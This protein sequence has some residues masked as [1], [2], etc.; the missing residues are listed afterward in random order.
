MDIKFTAKKR[1]PKIVSMLSMALNQRIPVTA[2]P[3][4]NTV[5]S[6]V[7]IVENKKVKIDVRDLLDDDNY[8]I[9]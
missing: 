1:Y 8:C 4:M 5:I 6:T 9:Y 3:R 7:H 2:T